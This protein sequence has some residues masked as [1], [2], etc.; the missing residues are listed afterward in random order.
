MKRRI[1]I[2]DDD[3]L[4]SNALAK[5][6]ERREMI[7]TVI[8]DSKSLFDVIESQNIEMVLLDI[9]MPDEN[10]I[11]VLKLI[12]EKYD[13][14]ELPVIMVTAIDDSVD[15]M[16]AFKLGANDYITK[17]VHVDV[18]VARIK[19]HLSIVDLHREGIQRR[20]LEAINAMITTYHHEI[21]NPLSVALGC[22]DSNLAKDPKDLERLK[23]SLWRI[24]DIVSKIKE[25]AESKQIEY[26][27]YI[28]RTK[29]VKLKK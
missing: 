19:A 16:D 10:G 29:M 25:V 8:N 3:Q 12:R 7:V 24:A 4:N 14:N 27:T 22:L 28:G 18:A 11:D 15:V 5:R 26:Q 17:P 13:R 9:V 20:E 21:N 23:T 2:L 6:L 1:L